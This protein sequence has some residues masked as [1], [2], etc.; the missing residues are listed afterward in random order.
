MLNGLIVPRLVGN[1][2]YN[3][4]ERRTPIGLDYLAEGT[5][6]PNYLIF[7]TPCILSVDI[8]I[9]VFSPISPVTESQISVSSYPNRITVAGL[10]FTV[11]RLILRESLSLGCLSWC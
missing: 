6:L 1:P 10:P 11:C 4:L 5:A 8:A 9:P 7:S 2:L 3:Y